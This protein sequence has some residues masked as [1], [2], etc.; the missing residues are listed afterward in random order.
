MRKQ[1]VA[2]LSMLGL[3]GPAIQSQVVTGATN[4]NSQTAPN[5]SKYKA[6]KSQI[7]SPRDPQSGQT[8]KLKLNQQNLRRQGVV[9]SG[10]PQMTATCN[11]HT[12]ANKNQLVRGANANTSPPLANNQLTKAKVQGQTTGGSVQTTQYTGGK[13]QTTQYTGGKVQ[14]TQYTG[15]KVQTTQYTG[16]KVQTTATATGANNQLTKA[17]AQG[18]TATGASRQNTGGSVALTKANNNQITKANNNQLTKAN[19]NQINNNAVAK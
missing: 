17:K 14:T 11:A 8:G 5:N 18:Q 19:N 9:N 15:G 6:Q 2:M 7:V 1:W 12:Q 4:Q 3:A 16:T 13:V 10:N